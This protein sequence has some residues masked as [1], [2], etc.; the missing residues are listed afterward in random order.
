LLATLGLLAG[1]LVSSTP[2]CG[3]EP[4]DEE[5]SPQELLVLTVESWRQHVASGSQSRAQALMLETFRHQGRERGDF[6]RW[7]D[8]LATSAP[9]QI[10]LSRIAF[11]LSEDGASLDYVLG[12]RG[13]G[14]GGDTGEAGATEGDPSSEYVV[15]PTETGGASGSCPLIQQCRAGAA[16]ECGWIARWAW[17]GEVWR[18][19]G[20]GEP[21]GAEIK[22]RA[23]SDGVFL[24]GGVTDPGRVVSAARAR[25]RGQPEAVELSPTAS[26]VWAVPKD[27]ALPPELS[28]DAPLPWFLELEVEHEGGETDSEIRFD[29]VMSSFASSVSPTGEAR[30]PITFEWQRPREAEGGLT[31]EVW[32]GDSMRWRSPR[33][34][35]DSLAYQGPELSTEKEYS[36]KVITY[37]LHWNE[38]VTSSPLKVL[39]DEALTPDPRS[40]D[41]VAGP[42]AGGTELTIRGR[43]F[44]AGA[45]VEIGS[46]ECGSTEVVSDREIT[47]VTPPLDEGSHHVAVI[48]PGGQVGLLEDAFSAL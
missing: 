15:T 30:Q 11:E 6:Q 13:C 29:T 32:E 46:K 37:D 27:T 3:E 41:P 23:S 40:I 17:D 9:L 44:L 43:H 21:W 22:L 31:A 14:R 34:F 24:I 39:P 5:L 38:A 1:A 18:A 47:C 42:A 19:A 26:S 4:A 48:N 8:G 33:V 16:A 10:E 25:W 28:N 36:L 35:T 7:M 2:G 12:V 45:R 20:D